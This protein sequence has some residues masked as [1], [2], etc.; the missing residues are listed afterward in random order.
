MPFGSYIAH[1]R[2]VHLFEIAMM[3]VANFTYPFFKKLIFSLT[4]VS[5]ILFFVF[6]YLDKSFATMVSMDLTLISWG[7]CNILA[8]HFGE[9][10]HIA[11]LVSIPADAHKTIRMM[12]LCF[13]SFIALYGIQ[14][15]V[16]RMLS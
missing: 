13:V 9:K 16:E 2:L 5:F 10:I 6:H 3:Q 7:I 15:L 14:D 4:L 1:R 12:G 8:W 11:N